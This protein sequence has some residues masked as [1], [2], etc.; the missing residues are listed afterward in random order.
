MLPDTFKKEK[1]TRD[2]NVPNEDDDEE[3]DDDD[4][5]VKHKQKVIFKVE[6]SQ[7]SSSFMPE[8]QTDSDV[9]W[10]QTPEPQTPRSQRTDI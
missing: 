10:S 1:R 2:E 4:I 9:Q 3:D 6:G 8:S 5:E 7:S